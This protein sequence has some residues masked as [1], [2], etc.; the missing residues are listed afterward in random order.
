MGA[1]IAIIFYLLLLVGGLILLVSGASAVHHQPRPVTDDGRCRA[2]GYSTRGNTGAHCPECGAFL[3]HN[4][5]AN[6]TP[7]EAILK[8]VFGIVMLLVFVASGGPF[9][10]LGML[11]SLL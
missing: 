7:P 1:A 2:C 6:G 3:L 10:L 8:I 11:G 4:P 9:L 5:T